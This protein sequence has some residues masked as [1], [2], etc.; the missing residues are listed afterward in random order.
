MSY[1]EDQ[2][3]KMA[4]CYDYDCYKNYLLSRFAFTI[5]RQHYCDQRHKIMDSEGVYA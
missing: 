3:M 1:Y 2:S 4:N 5:L